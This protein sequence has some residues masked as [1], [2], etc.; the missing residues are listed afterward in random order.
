MFIAGRFYCK[1]RFVIKGVKPVIRENY[2]K[3]VSGGEGAKRITLR[4]RYK[5]NVILYI[6][7]QT[8]R[9]AI[10]WNPQLHEV[11]SL[12]AANAFA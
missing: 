12:S 9:A 6:A 2:G 10:G 4:T 1:Y 11:F 5:A 3:V 7:M 8:Y